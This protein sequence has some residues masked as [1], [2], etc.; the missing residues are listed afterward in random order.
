MGTYEAKGDR[1]IKYR[2]Q[3]IRELHTFQSYTVRHVPRSDNA[4]ADILSKLIH[5]APEHISKIARIVE[6]HAAKIDLPQVVPIT[7]DDHWITDLIK[8][9]QTGEIPTAHARARKVKLRAPRFKVLE[10]KLYRRSYSGPLMRCL[11]AFEADLVMTE[12]HSGICSAHQG[13]RSLARRILLMGY[14]WPSIQLDCEDL[15]RKCESC[16][17]FAKMPGRPATFYKSVSSA[18][19]FARWGVDILGPFPKIAGRKKFIIV[20]VDYFS[21]WVEAEPLATITSQ[22]YERFLW[23]NVVSRFGVPV[24]LV[25]DNGKQF[26]SKSFQNFLAT[27][28]T[29]STRISVA[30]PQGNGQVQNANRT[31]LNGLKKKLDSAGRS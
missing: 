29:R 28:G 30:Y 13:G 23:R 14:Y 15:A 24:Q 16:Q 21:K 10:G 8:Y 4:D 6:V 9:L 27:I 5:Q 26:E 19:P 2:D 20:A 12:L 1:L 18:K 31:I 7:E 3:A 22:Q 11:N 17:R 25:T